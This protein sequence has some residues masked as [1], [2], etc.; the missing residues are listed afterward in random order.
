[1]SE[2]LKCEAGDFCIYLHVY[3]ISRKVY[4]THPLGRI[5]RLTC[6]ITWR[7]LTPRDASIPQFSVVFCL[8][9]SKRIGLSVALWPILPSNE[10]LHRDDLLMRAPNVHNEAASNLHTLPIHRGTAE[11]GI[12]WTLLYSGLCLG[13]GLIFPMATRVA[14]PPCTMSA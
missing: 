2:A 11:Q 3:F 14:A 6:S 12:S 13:I 10:L 7:M 1:M 8:E 9:K 4:M 5:S